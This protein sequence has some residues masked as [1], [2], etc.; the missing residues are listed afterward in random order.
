MSGYNQTPS[1]PSNAIS[2]WPPHV[3]F[4]LMPCLI[5]LSCHIW[6]HSLS[7]L[8]IFLFSDPDLGYTPAVHGAMIASYS[9]PALFSS[10]LGGFVY[11]RKRAANLM[12][13]SVVI[14][15]LGQV[16]FLVGITYRLLW[17][18]FVGQSIAGMGSGASVVFQRT[19]LCTIFSSATATAMASAVAFASVGRTL[20]KAVVA[21]LT[22]RLG[23]YL[24]VLWL[25]AATT[26][27]SF[28]SAVWFCLET[29][30][31]LHAAPPAI[32]ESSRSEFSETL[33]DR[34]GG[35]DAA[36]FTPRYMLSRQEVEAEVD[37]SAEGDSRDLDRNRSASMYVGVQRGERPL[38]MPDLSS[39]LSPVQVAVARGVTD[40]NGPVPPHFVSTSVLRGH[41]ERRNTSLEPIRAT[42]PG[43]IVGGAV[44]DSQIPHL[45]ESEAP[46]PGRPQVSAVSR[47]IDQVPDRRQTTDGGGA[48]GGSGGRG[49]CSRLTRRLRRTL[50]SAKEGV[51]FFTLEFWILCV[52]HALFLAWMHSFMNFSPDLIK[53]TWHTSATKAGYLAAVVTGIVVVAVP[54]L[55]V[56][57]D[58]L[59][60]GL[61]VL[62]CG[63]IVSF[64]AL[65]LLSQ[66]AGVPS[67]SGARRVSKGAGGGGDETLV[68]VSV[69]SAALRLMGS[70][71]GSSLVGR[72]FGLTLN[73]QMNLVEPLVSLSLLAVSGFAQLSDLRRD[74]MGGERGSGSI[75]HW[76]LSEENSRFSSKVLSMMRG[77]GGERFGSKKP[78]RADEEEREGRDGR[79][80][81]SLDSMNE[82][83]FGLSGSSLSFSFS[84]ASPAM[85]P[86]SSSL[87]EISQRRLQQQHQSL[88]SSSQSSFSSSSVPSPT[89]SSSSGVAE[90][91]WDLQ[92]S[93]SLRKGGEEEERG[94]ELASDHSKDGKKAAEAAT[95]KEGT[96]RESHLDTSSSPASSISSSSSTRE[97][98]GDGFGGMKLSPSLTDTLTAS[99][100]VTV[101]GIVE[102]VTPTIILARMPMPS[103]ITHPD[104]IGI[105][106]GIGEIFSAPTVALTNIVFGAL[107][108]RYNSY[109]PAVVMLA[110]LNLTCCLLL[111]VLLAK[112]GRDRHSGEGS[113]FHLEGADEAL[114]QPAASGDRPREAGPVQGVGPMA[115]PPIIPVIPPPGPG[116]L[117]VAPRGIQRQRGQTPRHHRIPSPTA[118]QQRAQ[119]QAQAEGGPQPGLSLSLPPITG[120]VA[121]TARGG[122][123][124]GGPGGDQTGTRR[125]RVHSRGVSDR[126]GEEASPGQPLTRDGSRHTSGSR[127]AF[128]ESLMD[129]SML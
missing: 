1:S 86:S 6:P 30:W 13:L 23:G 59:S 93:V 119:N 88:S 114:L 117:P 89:A 85:T 26:A 78:F 21:P 74:M 98:D 80:L 101:L 17:V 103:S 19:V 27:V 128:S 57:V 91:Q 127:L 96:E 108:I 31:K 79:L 9:L 49:L 8:A 63:S 94:T 5:S 47:W 46:G 104:Y 66:I 102:S 75:S 77:G 65:A 52:L 92:R 40:G 18:S 64:L 43:P 45:H 3:R 38:H 113:P 15:W 107:T 115:S 76:G 116:L 120:A 69:R 39:G 25:V 34:S 73:S 11:S 81:P 70:D 112:K 61:E 95:A 28:I 68:A 35:A 41:R 10:F 16:V 36:G 51:R 121:A 105:G 2:I 118:D 106:F 109:S 84:S 71:G 54:I 48:L 126:P 37:A 82:D 14:E 55:G 67:A 60:V 50:R 53:Q 97:G 22:E 44:P 4:L 33:N 62:F 42:L 56:A 83:F 110:V 125:E 29:K 24:P 90:A 72:F 99:L 7:V 87:T 124:G 111:L 129:H 58:R 12:L 32:L 123:A 100:M 122:E 20:A